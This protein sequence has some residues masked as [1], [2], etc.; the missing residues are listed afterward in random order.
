MIEPDKTAVAVFRVEVRPVTRQNVGV[1]IDLHG[2]E[3]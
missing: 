1:Q 3:L 2:L